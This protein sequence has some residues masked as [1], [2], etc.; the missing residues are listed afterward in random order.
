MMEEFFFLNS[1][2]FVFLSSLPLHAKKRQLTCL[3][4]QDVL[5]RAKDLEM[6]LF[7]HLEDRLVP[8]GKCPMLRR[9]YLECPDLDYESTK[10]CTY[11]DLKL[12]TVGE[13]G[14]TCTI[15]YS[16]LFEDGITRYTIPTRR[17]TVPSKSPF[18][19]RDFCFC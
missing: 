5:A 6:C 9:I 1:I 8:Q 3:C 13:K 12:W 19:S 17:S 10:T 2:Q 14:L 15:P 11:A 18:L 16:P 7:Y 4:R